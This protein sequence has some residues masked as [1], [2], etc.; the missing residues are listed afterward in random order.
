MLGALAIPP[1]VSG[2]SL[3]GEILL[4]QLDRRGVAVE[5]VDIGRP[6]VDSHSRWDTVRR[7]ATVAGMPA[8]LL[9][10]FARLRRRAHPIVF[11]LQIGQGSAALARDA[12]LF[13]AVLPLGLP[14]VVHVHGSAFRNAYDQAPPVLRAIIAQALRRASAAVVLSPSLKTMFDGLVPEERIVVVPNGVTRNVE[15]FARTAH[16]RREGRRF[17]ALFLSNL[18][19]S[20]GYGAFLQ[21]AL[22]AERR[23]LEIDFVIAG[24][25]T[26][27]TTIDPSVF[28]R[29]HGLSSLKYLGAIDGEAKLRVFAE[30]DVFVLPSRYRIEGQPISILEAMHFGM[31]IVTCRVGAVPDIIIEDENGLFV[32][33]DDPEGLLLVLDRL[34]RDDRLREAMSLRNR[35]IAAS[36]YTADAHGTAMMDLL[37]R[38]ARR[39]G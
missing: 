18:L 20:K 13:A 9:A 33:P 30:S 17:T 8:R 23:G 4:D 1:P 21:A 7:A 22:L 38:A 14:I 11:Y 3:A 15:E 19:E 6:F 32:Q 5:V 10:H 35:A 36:R 26:Q 2:Q 16:P 39:S 28:L 12:L 34:R 29:D 31:P 24:A 37:S 25:K 27:E